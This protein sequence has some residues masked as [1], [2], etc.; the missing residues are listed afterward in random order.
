VNPLPS[1]TLNASPLAAL[2]PPQ[3]T[4]ITATVNPTGGS[5]VWSLNGAT[6]PGATGNTL[7]PINVNGIG[8]YQAVYTDPNGCV[9]TSAVLNITAM[10]S[11][12]LWVYPVPNTGTF[13]VRFYN[14]TGEAATLK[15]YNAMGQ[16]IYQQALTLGI[17]YSNTVVNLGNV[18]AGVYV[19]KVVNSSNLELAAKRI[20]VYHP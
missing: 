14:Q 13:N 8:A 12:N 7:G 17:T 3:I 5:F 9:S 20:V 16:V 4:T 15:V 11:S 2:L 19:V 10:A 18:P 1:I 6:I